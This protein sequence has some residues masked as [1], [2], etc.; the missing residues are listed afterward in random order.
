M[1]LFFSRQFLLFYCCAGRGYIVAFT[2]VLTIC[3]MYHTC[4]HHLRQYTLSLLFQYSWNSFNQCQLSI[5]IQVYT[6]FVLYSP[7][8]NMVFFKKRN[9]IE[10]ILKY[11]F[12]IKK[13]MKILITDKTELK[14]E[15]VL[16]TYLR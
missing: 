13:Y 15:T 1:L 8:Y 12:R 11:S 5:Y 4:I 7:S 6:V 14:T 2:K 10:I 16:K 3:Q 9:K